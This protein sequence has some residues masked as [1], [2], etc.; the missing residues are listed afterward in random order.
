MVGILYISYRLSFQ[1]TLAAYSLNYKL[2][3]EA[4]I[5][6]DDAAYPNLSKKSNFYQTAISNYKIKSDEMDTKVWQRVSEIASGSQVRIA[7]DPIQQI[8]DTGIN[9]HKVH[10]QNFVFRG[11]YFQ[12]VKLLDT[13]SSSAGM[14]QLSQ[15]N[16]RIPKESNT[17]RKEL[18]TLKVVWS[19]IEK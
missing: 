18:L 12:F 1:H 16:I 10:N 17:D 3:N 13:L 5:Q 4:S 19:A 15:L 14:G 11:R 8:P 9:I 2:R 7:Y 6:R